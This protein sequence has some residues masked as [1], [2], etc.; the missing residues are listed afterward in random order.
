MKKV[1]MTLTLSLAMLPGV[2]GAADSGE[3]L[4]VQKSGV[5]PRVVM[6]PGLSG[7]AFGFRHVTEGLDDAGVTWAIIE[8]LAIGASPRPLAADYSLT[9]QA[10]R[11]AAVLADLGSQPKIIVGH[12]VSGS[13]A[14]RLALR[15]PELVRTVVSIEG[16]PEENAATAT[17]RSSLKWAAVAARL[18]GGRLLRD[19]FQADLEAASGDRSWITGHVVRRYF[20]QVNRDLSAAIAALQAMVEAEEP[21]SLRENLGRIESDVTLLVGAA[22]H[23]GSVTSAEIEIFRAGLLHFSLQ[24]VPDAGHFI[25]EEQPAIVIRLLTRLAQDNLALDGS[26]QGPAPIA[27][28]RG[29]S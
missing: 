5:A 22:P 12:G 14:M 4:N 26:S 28:G 25:F 20:A 23:A 16:G 27:S 13:I 29:G 17:V 7:C 3:V 24:V 10:D 18:G 6:M 1:L 11:V 2:G 8:P 19:R 9:A 15:H 21:Q